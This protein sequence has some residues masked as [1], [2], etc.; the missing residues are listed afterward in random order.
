MKTKENFLS[1]GNRENNLV[2]VISGAVDGCAKATTFFDF[3]LA[4]EALT[5]INATNFCQKVD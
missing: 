5:Q 4:S 1:F 2:G 3:K